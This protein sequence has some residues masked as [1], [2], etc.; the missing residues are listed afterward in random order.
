MKP[1]S[2]RSKCFSIIFSTLLVAACSSPNVRN[3]AGYQAIQVDH[4]VS[5]PVAGV[6]IEAQDIVSMTDK[7]LR[8]ILATPAIASLKT[9]PRIII[10]SS[11]FENKGSQPIN[12][13]LIIDRLRVELNRAANGR[14]KFIG[15]KYAARVQKERELKR[16]GVTDIGTT[17]LTKAQAGVDYQLVG[18][19]GSL[20]SYQSGIQ[21]RYNQ[22]TFE[23]LDLESDE[24]IWSNN[25]EFQKAGGDDAVYR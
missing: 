11:D 17:G 13:D 24:L 23:M 3:V 22:I 21:Q 16:E 7:M 2:K 15:R 25:Y 8:D 6:G 19:I 18:S 14:M 1:S 5:G 4:T 10:D 9:P 20:D 12:K